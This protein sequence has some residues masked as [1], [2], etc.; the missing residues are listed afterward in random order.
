MESHMDW[1]AARALL[2]WQFEM[3]AS[4]CI[5]EAPINRYEL[6]Q[7]V[8][9]KTPERAKKAAP[10]VVAEPDPATIAKTLAEGAKSRE[11]LFDALATFEG[12]SLRKGA[13]G[14]VL[15]DGSP[16]ARVMVLA[17]G[18][19]KSDDEAGRVYSGARGALFD[20][21]FAAIGLDR[22][23]EAPNDGLYVANVIPWRLPAARTLNPIDFKTMQH[24]AMRHVELIAPEVIVIMGNLAAQMFLETR[25]V[26]QL[27]GD[28]KTVMGKPAIAIHPPSFL[29]NTPLA[30]RE[31]WADLL[32][33][34]SKLGA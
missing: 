6:E 9:V 28:W 15:A 18:P 12:C 25:S 19:D 8:Q 20:K 26:A 17:D 5:A 11:A 30:K 23:S 2:E 3:G 29:M 13:R 21:M 27:R 10:A 31:A 14:L 32:S 4:D 1:H 33:L 16:N 22:A 7:K 34:K 24:F